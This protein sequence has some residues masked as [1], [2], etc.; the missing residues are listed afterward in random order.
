MLFNSELE[1]F[2]KNKF[3]KKEIKT[4]IVRRRRLKADAYQIIEIA[5]RVICYTK[6]EINLTILATTNF[7]SQLEDEAKGLGQGW[8]PPTLVPSCSQDVDGGFRVGIKGKDSSND[9][10]KMRQRG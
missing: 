9:K 2:G 6:F 4:K 1:V 7:G 5:K 10:L 8:Q 3:T